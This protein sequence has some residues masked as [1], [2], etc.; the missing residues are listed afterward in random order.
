[1]TIQM[2][3]RLVEL[4][5]AAGLSQDAVAERIG[6]SRQAVSKWERAEAAPDTD[7][8]IAL[9][10]LYNVSVDELLCLDNPDSKKDGA[11][12][13]KDESND[14]KSHRHA[15]DIDLPFVKI[16]IDGDEF[17]KAHK[18]KSK[19]NNEKTFSDATD[20]FFEDLERDLEDLEDTDVEIIEETDD[21]GNYKYKFE[22]KSHWMSFPYPVLTVIAYLVMGFVWSL[23][24]PG[25]IVFLTIP[26]YY[27]IASGISKRKIP[28]ISVSFLITAAYL[29]MGIGWGMWHPWWIMFLAIPIFEF[30]V[31]LFKK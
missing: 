27:W 7:N 2:A 23:W 3:N 31:K 20:E 19:K 6:V 26:I 29:V 16:K 10:N 9:A 11:K 30:F 12:Y 15:I 4:R 21:K 5:K 14:K 28:T 13:N 22:H 24:H 18:N 17:K 8:L 25:W 1:M